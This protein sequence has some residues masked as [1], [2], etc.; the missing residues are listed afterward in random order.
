[1]CDCINVAIGSY[2]NQ[3]QVIRPN[4]MMVDNRI[5][6][7]CLDRCIAD[8]VI[9][10]WKIGISTTGCCCGHNI[11]QGYIGVE[12][13]DITKMKKIGY[14]VHYNKCRPKDEDSFIPKTNRGEII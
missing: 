6:D 8:E 14:K 4:H 2:D 12:F 13:E 10:L 9:Q 11:K 5:L 3:V 7:I 1:M